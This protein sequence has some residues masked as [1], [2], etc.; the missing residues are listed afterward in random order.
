MPT[1]K[2]VK[3]G[4]V[5]TAA[6]GVVLG[7]LAYLVE[8]LPI[9][10]PQFMLTVDHYTNPVFWI[11][12][13]VIAA[14]IGH[15]R[16][17]F[18]NGQRFL[19][20][21]GPDGWLN[22]Y[23][24][25]DSAGAKAIRK[26]ADYLRPGL[27]AR[28]GLRLQP[29]SEYATCVGELVTGNR[30][31]RRRKVFSP[32]SRG[33]MILGPQGSGKSSLLVHPLLDFPGGVY[34]TST[35]PEL[36]NMA[37]MLRAQR[38]KVFVFNPSGLGGLESTFFFDP[39]EGCRDQAVADARAWGLVR[40][41]GGAAGVDRSDFWATKAVEIIRCY[42]MAAALVGYDMGAVHH[43][44]TNPDD[45]APVTI[46]QSPQF[47]D[48]VPAAWIGTLLTHLAASPNTKTGYFATVVSCVGFMDNPAVAAACR[49]RPSQNFDILEFLRNGTLFVIGSSDDKRLAPL[50]T[51][52]TEHIFAQAK[53]VAAAS[54]GGR[55]PNGLAFM[56]DEIAQMT[57][58]P[59]DRWAAD[60]RGW[61]ITVMAVFQDLAQ[62]RTT[63]GP[64]RAKTI[65]S[66]LPT[67]IVLPGVANKDD[68]EELAYLAGTR[69]VEKI[70]MGESV[71]QGTWSGRSSLS[72]HKQT[73]TEPVITGHTI[74]GLPKWHA[75]VLG[76]APRACV[77]KFEPGYMRVRREHRKLSA[78]A[79][80]RNLAELAEAPAAGTGF[81][82]QGA[83]A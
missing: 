47:A 24:L 30:A 63:W 73:V 13:G 9:H 34:V 22:R 65:Y 36:A 72:S 78:A 52:L 17:Y 49:P 66:N 70:S 39:V 55:L 68:L 77:I 64:D 80:S 81:G 67:K 28:V 25:R 75:Y 10:D 61:N 29:M 48:V 4:E 51:A 46:L 7:G 69:Q 43:W 40:G 82:P 35:K 50:L 27:P 31:M 21:L 2:D 74:Y 1:D 19:R 38:G 16:W 18:S 20:V 14:T 3:R 6:G 76:L 26:H 12:G 60:S 11:A 83:P 56:L 71:Q 45:P 42:L 33:L 58:V 15:N 44:A 23:D 8:H 57:P 5:K 53:V 59:L 32:H 41:G 54:P 79:R 62:I 37:A